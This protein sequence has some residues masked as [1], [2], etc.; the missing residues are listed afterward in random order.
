[1]ILYRGGSDDDHMAPRGRGNQRGRAPR[2]THPN[3]GQNYNFL[4]I[5]ESFSQNL[6]ILKKSW[7]ILKNSKKN[8]KF[9]KNY[10]Y[11]PKV[12]NQTFFQ[13]FLSKNSVFFEHGWVYP[14]N[15]APEARDMHPTVGGEVQTL[16]RQLGTQLTMWS[17]HLGTPPRLYSADR[18]IF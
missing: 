15:Q 16:G 9:Q 12:C 6:N 5:R 2:D 11:F 4:K 10:N 18:H 17:M 14:Y 8:W 7:K 13:K 3:V 1:M